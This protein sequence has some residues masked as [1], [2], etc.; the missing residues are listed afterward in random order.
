MPTREELTAIYRQA[1]QDGPSQEAQDALASDPHFA[2][3]YARHVLRKRLPAEVEAVIATDPLSAGRY[4]ED[5]IQG[6]WPEGE[7]GI[8]THPEVALRYVRNAKKSAWPEAEPVLLA[9]ADVALAV[10]YAVE[11]KGKWPEL[12]DKLATKDPS[13]PDR[14]AYEAAYP[15]A[16]DAGGAVAEEPPK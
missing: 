2:C 3:L 1:E 11:V 4:A 10:A 14:V 16:L 8:V 12:E 5:V 9:A 7:K 15:I 13:D 6:E